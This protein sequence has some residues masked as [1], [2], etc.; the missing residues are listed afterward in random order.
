MTSTGAGTTRFLPTVQGVRAIA[1]ILVV[2]FHA[3]PA[4]VPGGYVGVDVFFVISGFLITRL[5][6]RE[7]EATGRI[8]FVA[9]YARRLRRLLPALVVVVL[10]V[11]A[12]SWMLHAPLERKMLTSSA[13][14]SLVY[15]SNVWFAHQATDYLAD[16]AH[17][18]P[19]LHTWSLSVEEQFYLV[20]PALIW[21]VVAMAA[22][23]GVNA[24]AR[25]RIAFAAV[26]LVSLALCLGLAG[27][28]RPW[29]FFGS[30]AR[31]WEFAAGAL[32]A[33]WAGRAVPRTAGTQMGQWV[34][35]ASLLVAAFFFSSATP[36]PGIAT[37]LPVAAT[38]ALLVSAVGG[39]TGPIARTL[40]ASPMA[41][42]GNLSYA[43][44]LWHWPVL[45]FARDALGLGGLL[46][47]SAALAVSLI[48]AWGTYILVENPV[49]F[50]RPLVARPA[51]SL[52]LAG[53]LTVSALAA[54]F[55]VRAMAVVSLQDSEQR[56]YETAVADQAD[57]YRKGCHAEYLEERPANCVFGAN[58]S[59]RILVLFGDSHAAQ[60]FPALE[61]LAVAAGWRLVPMTKSA[62]P[63][64][65]FE[66]FDP[67][68]GRPYVEC[69]RW[70]ERA[71]QRI[72]ELRPDL[73]VISSS[74]KNSAFTDGGDIAMRAWDTGVRELLE[75]V[76]N[77]SSS[78]LIIEDTPRPDFSV[79]QCLA[80]AQWRGLDPGSACAFEV[81]D[82]SQ[83]TI[84]RMWSVGDRG[85]PNVRLFDPTSL[86]CPQRTCLTERNGMVLYS[87]SHHLTATFSRSLA[88][89][90]SS[91]LALDDSTRNGP[92][93]RH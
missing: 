14:A 51:A 44:Y 3:W 59:P 78:V 55:Q 26:A 2:L 70:R 16:D 42:L 89:M 65:L 10:A 47:T 21:L 43:W 7:V 77:A 85:V 74:R 32:V 48:L 69:T 5:L 91:V 76:S 8:D 54:T 53:V 88:P 79:P 40:A 17:G 62:C 81:S 13:V 60:W 38:C 90:L 29:A 33:L 63:A 82:A 41:W 83:R 4:I 64:P 15:L 24:H 35:L 66:P 19:L 23:A 6:L 72:R 75:R 67:N 1:V 20:W 87:D 28:L 92:D 45:T 12:A 9:F 27:Y 56:R 46:A 11:M 52:W 31:A 30:P 18:N 84:D 37:V 34:A 25:M 39:G 36:Y 93:E 49:R 86:V 71:L 73:L 58:S 22:R 80:R 61:R 68:L 50:A 57:V